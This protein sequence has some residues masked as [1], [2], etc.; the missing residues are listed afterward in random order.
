MQSPE[1]KSS[2]LPTDAAHVGKA[3]NTAVSGERYGAC[4]RRRCTRLPMLPLFGEQVTA[5]SGPRV[6]VLGPHPWHGM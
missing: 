4:G 6:Q 2:V 1:H 5:D 3:C